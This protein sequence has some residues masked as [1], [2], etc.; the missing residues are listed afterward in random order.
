MA[1]S[2]KE[3]AAELEK[4]RD[5][6]RYHNRKYYVEDEP[7]ISD[8]EYDRLFDRLL[9]L[10]R[11]HPDLITPDSPSQ[12]VG[13]EPSKRFEPAGHRVP[14]LSLSKVTSEESF[15][16]F[17]R[18]CRETLE[19]DKVTYVTEP[20]LDGL[21]VE[22][23]YEE[24]I[25]AVGS[26]RGDGQ[27]GENVTPN[28]KTIKNVPLSL[29]K[30]SAKKYPL[31]EV[32]GEVIMK[33]SAFNKLNARLEKEG[34]PVLANPR[35]GAAG[36]VRQ[37]DPKITAARPLLFFAYGISE[38]RLEGLDRQ[39]RVQEFLDSEGFSVNELI[40]VCEGFGEVA[41]QFESLKEKRPELDYEIDGMVVK[42]DSFEQQRLLGT[43]SRAPR[44]AVAWKFEAEVAQT[45]L[46]DIEFSVGRTGTVTPV[47]KLEPVKVAGVTVSNASLHNEDIMNEL[48]VRIGDTVVVRRAGD[49]I[50]EV[51]EV[52]TEKRPKNAKKIGYPK[53]C[54]SCGQP[55]TRP[56]GEAAYRCQNL[57]C[58]AQLEGRL[59]HFASKGGFDIDGLGEKLARQM[60]GQKLVEDPADLFY[61]SKEKL[62]P[63]DLMAEKRAENLLA[64]I[65][66]SRH[67]ELPRAIYALGI[68]GVGESAAR[69]LAAEFQTIDKLADADV[70][71]IEDIAGIGPVIAQSVAEFFDNKQNRRMLEKL[72]KGGVEFPEYKAAA[73]KSGR[74]S[75]KTLV[76][77]GTLS[78]PRKHFK[79]LIEQHGGKVTGSVSKSTDYLLVGDDAGSKLD[80]AKKLEVEILDE[81]S[82]EGMMQE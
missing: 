46:N 36:S 32:R 68:V 42:V 7:E 38:G 9:Q 64:A 15:A 30:K 31:L 6:V 28:I 17:D 52:I 54:P 25:L 77:T 70:A 11:E 34:K 59:F 57:A 53:N 39:H 21:A 74:L 48:D 66:R 16:E 49:V 50:P 58:P 51:V 3:V 1:K 47:A 45:K 62:L 80:K 41:G 37:L 33:R 2:I 72:R 67:V 13:A 24:G 56:E 22:L 4:L 60:I 69:V 81:E 40:R 26:T 79:D 65:D 35:N 71:Q 75:G 55:I 12:R 63:L 23:V 18:R 44:W 43:I 19:V 10:E 73:P 5:Q 76:I 20:K 78:K 82:F 14:M 61:L 8:A 29:S 27:T